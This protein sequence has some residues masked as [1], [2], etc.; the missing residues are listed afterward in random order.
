MR[1]WPER[2]VSRGEAAASLS[3]A[4]GAEYAADPARAPGTVY[5]RPATLDEFR[6]RCSTASPA[7][8]STGCTG[9]S[10][11][12]R[13]GGTPRESRSNPEWRAEFR[14]LLPDLDERDICGSCFA[15]TGYVAAPEL[16]GDAARAAALRAAAPARAALDARLRPQSRRP[17]PPLDP[18]PSGAVRARHAGAARARAR[19]L[20]R[21]CGRGRNGGDRARPRPELS[22]LARHAAARLR[23]PAH[24][25]GHAGRAGR[26]RRALRW[27]ALR[28]GD[29]DPAGDV[30]ANLGPEGAAVLAGGDRR[31]PRAPA[32]LRL[33]G[34]G[35]LGP[36]A[37]PAEQGF[38]YAYDKTL[39]DLAV[40]ADAAEFAR[41]CGPGWTSSGAWRDS[42]RTTTRTGPRARSLGQAPRRR[43]DHV[44]LA[45]S[46]VFPRRPVRGPHQARVRP[47]EPGTY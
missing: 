18:R 45:L 44:L 3:I 16:G 14:A 12:H 27:A 8:A 35:V 1:S 21:G 23:N 17:R 11:A 19:E 9:W 24:V 31:R 26:R 46:A 30:R 22:R 7:K 13:R 29:A 4:A 10:L 39:Y 20:R 15:V 36:R 33:H 40:R 25:G 28:Y 38:D 32:G 42:S 47:P 37:A 5:G 6:T 41:I 34:R 43:G 2:A